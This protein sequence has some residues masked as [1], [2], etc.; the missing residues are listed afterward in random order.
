ML[1]CPPQY[2]LA[3]NYR[4]QCEQPVGDAEPKRTFYKHI[5]FSV[6]DRGAQVSARKCGRATVVLHF[7][8]FSEIS[9]FFVII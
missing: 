1:S 3:R 5:F 2:R 9:K 4:N 8:I 7:A 6:T